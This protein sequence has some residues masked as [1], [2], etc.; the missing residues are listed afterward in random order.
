ML[1]TLLENSKEGGPLDALPQEELSIDKTDSVEEAP[2]PRSSSQI[3]KMMMTKFAYR[4]GISEI[5]GNALLR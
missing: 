5:D 2:S 3:H 1:G 4:C